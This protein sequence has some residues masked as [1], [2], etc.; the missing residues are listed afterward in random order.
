M[1][2]SRKF[3]IYAHNNDSSNLKMDTAGS[4]IIFYVNICVLMFDS[5]VILITQ[6]PL[7]EPTVGSID[8]LPDTLVSSN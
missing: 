2:T 7:N 8:Y 6:Y 1:G 5:G 4:I 3:Q